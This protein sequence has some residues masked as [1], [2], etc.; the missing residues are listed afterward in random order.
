MPRPLRDLRAPYSPHVHLPNASEASVAFAV[1][2]R[3]A[4]VGKPR[5]D[6]AKELGVTPAQLSYVLGHSSVD[7]VVFRRLVNWL[8]ESAP[9][10]P[11]LSLTTFIENRFPARSLATDSLPSRWLWTLPPSTG[12]EGVDAC[13][14]GELLVRWLAADPDLASRTNRLRTR[15]DRIDEVL[16]GLLETATGVWGEG[17]HATNLLGELILL[18][19]AYVLD[20]ITQRIGESALGWTLPRSIRHALRILRNPELSPIVSVESEGLVRDEI[21]FSLT[22]LM[23]AERVYDPYPER[24]LLLAAVREYAV[25]VRSHSAGRRKDCAEWLSGIV[26]DPSRCERERMYAGWAVADLAH[27]YH[28]RSEEIDDTR[29]ATRKAFVKARQLSATLR[30]AAA[31]SD[32]MAYTSA[33]ADWMFPTILKIDDLAN[34]TGAQHQTIEHRPAPSGEDEIV[35]SAL[36]RAYGEAGS[37]DCTVSR[38]L[39]TAT[40][41]LT[42][43]AL[44]TV[45]NVKRRNC[46]ET[47]MASGLTDQVGPAFGTVAKTSTAPWWL[48]ESATFALGFLGSG[49]AYGTLVSLADS[50]APRRSDHTPS[51]VRH[52]ALWGLAELRCESGDIDAATPDSNKRHFDVFARAAGLERGDKVDR[53]LTNAAAYGIALCRSDDRYDA[54][55]KLA[56][57]SDQTTSSV[58]RWGLEM[59]QALADSARVNDTAFARLDRI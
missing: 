5:A 52:C 51:D 53:R 2:A 26:Q 33:V 41:N 6:V 30:S 56:S 18:A 22:S 1:A 36:L 9:T 23:A 3:L 16:S 47:L 40:R 37:A 32:G 8:D 35:R 45:D 43:T 48:V 4:L 58:A 10:T 14:L 28:R 55:Q 25:Q 7:N 42:E 11:M 39:H 59:T 29:F 13:L 38:E 27:V 12:R 46:L 17:V 20:G 24:C 54:L 49:R 15:Q 21:W 34:I 31:D 57:S 19:P 50:Q 44:L